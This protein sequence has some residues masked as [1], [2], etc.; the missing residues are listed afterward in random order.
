[1]GSD[2]L[3]YVQACEQAGGLG[4]A[5]MDESVTV[6]TPVSLLSRAA[7]D[8]PDA[9]DG[10]AWIAGAALGNPPLWASYAATGIGPRGSLK[11][12][13]DASTTPT[14]AKQPIPW[15]DPPA[16]DIFRSAGPGTLAACAAM[17]AAAAAARTPS[18][19]ARSCKDT[20]V[21]LFVCEFPSPAAGAS[22]TQLPP[23]VS[24]VTRNSMSPGEIVGISVA[25]VVALAMLITCCILF[26]TRSCS[27]CVTAADSQTPKEARMFRRERD[28][29]TRAIIA[30]SKE[31]PASATS[32]T[33]EAAHTSPYNATAHF[34]AVSLKIP[35]M[36]PV[37]NG[38]GSE[39]QGAPI[40]T[41]VVRTI[42]ALNIE[43]R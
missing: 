8:R 11:P 35:A 13:R 33:P 40:A 29:R 7:A 15:R 16:P 12:V 17:D 41:R 36:L 32:A 10:I 18:F 5:P 6:Q 22:A 1:V 37:H 26:S 31:L 30:A 28:R 38:S 39:A 25:A 2:R 21:P 19:V 23:I 9:S 4:L 14:P 24:I 42:A 34:D 3:R 43:P 27:P 20:R